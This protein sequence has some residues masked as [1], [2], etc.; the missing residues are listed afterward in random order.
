MNLLGLLL[1]AMTAKTALE[2]I[3]KKTGLSEKQIK[4]LMTLA[5]PILLKYLTQNA[6]SSD[7]VSSL[8]GALTQHT[9]K[10]DMDLQLKEADEKDGGKIIS[11][12]LGNKETEVTQNLSAQSGLSAEQVN[13]ILAIMAP[14]LM[15]GVSEAASNTTAAQGSATPTLSFGATPGIFSALLGSAASTQQVKEEQNSAT[16]GMA[17]LQALLGARK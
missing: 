6:S 10:K 12:I 14:A 15:S 11:H 1:K 5:I 17:L 3:A 8:L 2:Q 16:N 9:N 7:G 4:T 13:Q